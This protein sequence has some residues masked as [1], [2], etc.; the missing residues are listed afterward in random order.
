MSMPM[1]GHRHKLAPDV[2]R[3]EGTWPV[4][5]SYS[6]QL[7]SCDGVLRKEITNHARVFHG[8]IE[9]R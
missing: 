8:A 4:G 1:P 6:L 2:R 7:L 5:Q 9:R 3:E